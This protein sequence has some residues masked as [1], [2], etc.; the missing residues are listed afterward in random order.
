[1]LL[2]VEP[3]W[4]QRGWEIVAGIGSNLNTSM[5]KVD[6]CENWSP[7]LNVLVLLFRRVTNNCNETIPV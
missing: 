6:G 7:Y 4:P 5:R 2:F 1:M 3:Q